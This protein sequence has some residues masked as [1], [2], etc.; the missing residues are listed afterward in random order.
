MSPTN[1][2]RSRTLV[3]TSIA[4]I[5]STLDDSGLTPLFLTQKPRYS[6]YVRPKK[7]FSAF[8]FNP[9]YMSLCEPCLR[10]LDDLWNYF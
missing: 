9:A 6:V 5:D 2:R 4:L 8:T 7:D 3:G 10:L 1:L